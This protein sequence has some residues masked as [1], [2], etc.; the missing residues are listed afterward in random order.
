[1]L[2]ATGKEFCMTTT[3]AILNVV[4]ISLVVGVIVGMHLWAIKTSPREEQMLRVAR[5]RRTV[6]HAHAHARAR[7]RGTRRPAF[8]Q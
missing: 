5:E 8:D 1:M 4:L 3:I 6:R 2:F 7:V